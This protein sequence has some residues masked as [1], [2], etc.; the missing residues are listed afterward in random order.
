MLSQGNYE[1]KQL[2]PIE[3]YYCVPYLQSNCSAR[4]SYNIAEYDSIY[5]LHRTLENF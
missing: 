3:F 4:P 1:N 2:K 5:N